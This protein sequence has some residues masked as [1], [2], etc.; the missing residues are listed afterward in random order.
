MSPRDF[1]SPESYYAEHIT[2]DI[3]EGF[4]IERGFSNVRDERKFHGNVESQTIHATSPSGKMTVMR[5][6]LCWRR[7]NPND[8]Y[9]A[10]QLLPK[11]INNDW[12][13]TLHNKVKHEIDEGVTHTLFIQ[14]EYE[15][16][17]YAA[18]IPQT[19]LVKIWCAQRDAS[20]G[21][22]AAGKLGRRTKNH[23]MNGSS[24][25]IWLHDEKAP[26]VNK[27]LWGHSGV[28]NLMS[29]K[30]TQPE[31][32]ENHD[33]TYDDLPG[34]DYSLL[35]SDGSPIIICKKSNVKRDPRVR[36]AVVLRA[37]G[38]CERVECGISHNY[39][40]FLDVHHI[41]GIGKSDRVWNCVALCPNCHREAHASP[42]QEEINA[43]LLKF[44]LHYKSQAT[45]KE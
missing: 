15:T 38:K 44:A 43:A 13:G 24:P 23:A 34:G 26:E 16:I 33:D 25:T 41:L 7:R 30:V 1:R 31:I 2:R 14:R 12:E 27:A 40:G 8:T 6:R 18:L 28:L 4:L 29:F 10:A 11:I 37:Q 3:I 39:P 42:D 17:S 9:S 45:L 32:S 19:E 21:L 20:K 5:V 36:K 22:I 35:G